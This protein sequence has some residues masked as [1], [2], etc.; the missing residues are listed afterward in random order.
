MINNRTGA[1][2]EM[3]NILKA[4]TVAW[5]VNLILFTVS[6][7]LWNY[8]DHI[9]HWSEGAWEGIFGTSVMTKMFLSAA[10]GVYIMD[11]GLDGLKN[12]GK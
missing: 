3:S 8:Y 7:F 6:L 2:K 11:H 4:L 9:G 5:F 1:N 12:E 10:I